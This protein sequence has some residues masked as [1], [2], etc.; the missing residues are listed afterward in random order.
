MDKYSVKSRHEVFTSD[1]V[2]APA[3]YGGWQV[4]NIGD[5]PVT[6]NS[7]LLDPSGSLAAVD[8]TQLPPNVIWED[9]ISIRFSQPLGANPRVVVTRL[10]Y[11]FKQI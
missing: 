3:D 2:L 7:V 5:T 9:S 10:K 11:D 8:F 6:V 4:A 1:T